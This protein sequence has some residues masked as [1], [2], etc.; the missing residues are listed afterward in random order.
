M[1]P[2]L[3]VALAF[4]LALPASAKTSRTASRAPA[5]SLP[6]RDGAVALDSLR[7][8]VVVID[9]WASWCGPCRQSFPWLAGLQKRYAERGLEVVAIDLDKDRSLADGFL[10]EVPA[11]FHVAFDPSGRTAEAYGV[12]AMPSSFV[13]GPGGR[14]L[15]SHAGFD[16]R[17]TGPMEAVILEA[18]A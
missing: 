15:Y 13:V 8:H 16:P 3:L 6:A 12:S 10:A 7:G 17:K 18:C 11:P 4:A 5:F 1:K 2:W 14:I 9:F